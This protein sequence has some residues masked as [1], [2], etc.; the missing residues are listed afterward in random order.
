M[1]NKSSQKKNGLYY[2]SQLAPS[3][4]ASQLQTFGTTP[5][6]SHTISLVF[7]LSRPRTW[8][9]PTISFL[10]GYVLTTGWNYFQLGVG[11][12]IACLVT[13]ATNIV[14]AYADRKEDVVN[15]PRRVFWLDQMGRKAAIGSV[16]IL[17]GF[18]TAL[19][20]YLGL[21]YMFVLSL[22]VFNSLFYSLPPLRFKA[23]PLPSL[24]SFSGAV[25]LAF[26]AGT[27]VT[28]RI[29]FAS[30]ML[31]LVTYFMFTYGTVKNLPDYS[32][33]KKAGTKTTATI[34]SNIGRAITF[35]SIL[36]VSPY[37]LLVSMIVVGLLPQ[38]YFLDLILF[39][40]L[41]F[42]LYNMR[43]AK[44]GE[45]LEKAH[46]YG[47]FYAISFLLFTLV[48]SSPTLKALGVVIGT[49]VW[50]LLVS[51]I[52]MDSRIENRDWE[53]AAPRRRVVPK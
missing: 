46:T 50:T 53:R 31:W 32:G 20:I 38:I 51:R 48:V 49:F 42:I 6:S 1:A 3:T 26:L 39:P 45:G 37:I 33:D 30:P 47:F 4:T 12:L 25:G 41:I 2:N 16:I 34:F 43:K 52:H 27:S 44:N 40:L 9:F 36:L 19:S 18:S 24:I 29:S 15:Q 11:L 23:R 5:V 22:G 14:N 13:G 17:Y 28:G 35:S 10:L 21:A 7:R 8:S